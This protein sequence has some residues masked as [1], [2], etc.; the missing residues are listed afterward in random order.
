MSE[1]T[2]MERIEAL[3]QAYA[4]ERDQLA[5]LVQEIQ[6]EIDRI[7]RR[8]T[9]AIKD[10]VR[11]VA[12]AHDRLRAEVE[13]RPELWQG[14]RRTVVI[15]GVRVGMAKGKGKIAWEDPAQVVRLIRRH[16]PEQADSLIRVKEEPIR[17]ALGNLT[18][19]ELRRI[20]CEVED[21]DD[22]VVIKPTDSQVDKLVQQLLQDAERIERQEVA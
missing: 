3:T 8:A 21:T 18:V 20:G 4:S 5:G 9:P 16:F 6:D 15:A 7:T 13:A 17:K 12:E 10:R 11:R 19:A 22:Q 2:P 1:E 14:K